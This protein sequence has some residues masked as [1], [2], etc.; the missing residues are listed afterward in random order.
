MRAWFRQTLPSASPVEA[1]AV[2]ERMRRKGWTEAEI[3][4]QILP[5]M[6]RARPGQAGSVARAGGAGISVPARVSNAWLD[7]QLPAMDREQIRFVVEELEQR[8]WPATKVAVAV[9]PHLLPKLPAEDADAI[10]AGLK[11]LGMTDDEIARLRPQ[12][13]GSR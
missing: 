5:Y 10:L 4:E 9:L 13:S 7:Q 1:R 12:G 8:G 11:R 2:L 3:A 6:P